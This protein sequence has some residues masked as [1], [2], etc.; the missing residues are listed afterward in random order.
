M[1]E[2]IKVL[3]KAIKKGNYNLEKA[4]QNAADRIIDNPQVLVWR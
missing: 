2:K 4:I 3:K 1:P